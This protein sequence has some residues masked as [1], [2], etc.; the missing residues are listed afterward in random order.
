MAT[1][2]LDRR[3]TLDF[4]AYLEFLDSLNDR[5]A[6]FDGRVSYVK[7][8]CQLIEDF[9][10]KAADEDLQSHS[11]CLRLVE[12]LREMW[13]KCVA[14][15]D[16]ALDQLDQHIKM[17]IDVVTSTILEINGEIKVDTFPSIGHAVVM[18][19]DASKGKLLSVS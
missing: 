17:D 3:T 1:L 5:I 15:R 14:E 7:Q 8:I 11:L 19:P 12:E 4:V 6:S 2:Q 10:I 9:S 16:K 18:G 13:R